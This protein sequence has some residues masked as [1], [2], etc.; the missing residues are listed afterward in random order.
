M[1]IFGSLPASGQMPKLWITG[2]KLWITRAYCG[3]PEQL[4]ELCTPRY[5][6]LNK[7]S[8]KYGLSK[9]KPWISCLVFSFFPQ[10]AKI[11][12]RH[13]TPICREDRRRSAAGRGCRR[14]FHFSTSPTTITKIHNIYKYRLNLRLKSCTIMVKVPLLFVVHQREIR[15]GCDQ[16]RCNLPYIGCGWGDRGCDT[17]A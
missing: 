14:V 6:G 10:C 11:P 15:N 12:A 9:F 17:R 13:E 2:E 4:F 8:P 16:S 1:S 7:A 3:E 5:G